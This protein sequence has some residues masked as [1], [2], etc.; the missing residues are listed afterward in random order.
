[1]DKKQ[2]LEE[3]KVNIRIVLSA[4]WTAI[5]FC[6]LYGDYFE[7]Y[8]PNKVAGL[9]SGDNLLDSPIKLFVTTLVMAVP[10]LMVLLTL[11]V[12]P[13]WAKGLNIGVG[14]FF[15]LFTL[16]VGISSLSSWRTFYVFLS[17]LESLLTGMVVYRAWRW[18]RVKAV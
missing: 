9:I 5:M 17:F 3:Y 4:F 13:S 18:P 14:V 15:T 8:V 2:P 10:A 11:V 6:Y 1:M 12:S 7:L 16:L